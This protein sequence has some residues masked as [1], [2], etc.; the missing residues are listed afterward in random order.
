MRSYK[1]EKISSK[2]KTTEGGKDY[3]SFGMQLDG[4]WYGGFGKP[5]VTDQWK[6]GNEIT[7]IEL[8]ETPKKDGSGVW[9]NWRFISPETRMSEI[10]SRLDTLEKF[11]MV[12]G[13][14][15]MQDNK[16]ANPLFDR[17]P[18]NPNAYRQSQEPLPEQPGESEDIDSSELPF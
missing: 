3:I 6:V 8:Y 9:R 18:I 14:K 17:K 13:A 7:G 10:E 11:V 16:K 4:E 15:A 2:S 5:G 12:G 1:I